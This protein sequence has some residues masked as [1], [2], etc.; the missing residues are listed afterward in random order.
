MIVLLIDDRLKKLG[1]S[2]AWLSEQTGIN[3]TSLHRMRRNI[4]ES[5][6]LLH[7]ELI[8]RA[9][10]CKPGDLIKIIDGEPGPP[11]IEKAPRKTTWEELRSS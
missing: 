2:A 8:L 11:Q 1:K 9:L 6:N 7:F 10:D 4:T 3:Q 5:V